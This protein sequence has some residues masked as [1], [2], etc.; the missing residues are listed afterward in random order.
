MKPLTKSLREA[1]R[2]ILFE[3]KSLEPVSF[4]QLEKAAFV[5]F[6]E[7]I[8]KFNLGRYDISF[9]KEQYKYPRGIIVTNAKGVSEV[10]AALALISEIGGAAVSVET[11]LT[12]GTLKKLKEMLK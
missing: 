11:V 12:S 8:G 10:R 3:I 2:Y 4:S 5:T 9:V 1:N 6:T 7:W